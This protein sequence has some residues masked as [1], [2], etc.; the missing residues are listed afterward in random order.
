M[1]RVDPFSKK[2]TGFVEK[3]QKSVDSKEMNLEERNATVV[4]YC[5]RP[6]TI[7]RIGP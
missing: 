1:V 2:I 7:A 3:P 5:F 4:F 6:E